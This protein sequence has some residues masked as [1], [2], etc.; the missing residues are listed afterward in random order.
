MYYTSTHLPESGGQLLITSLTHSKKIIAC[1]S[2]DIV[3]L[4]K[5]LKV[6]SMTLFYFFQNITDTLSVIVQT[7]SYYET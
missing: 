1:S 4:K 6:F 3:L 7:L 5:Q 2:T